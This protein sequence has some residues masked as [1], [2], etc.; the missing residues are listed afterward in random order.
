MKLRGF[1]DIYGDRE[2]KI[3]FIEQVAK[4]RLSSFL[5]NRVRFPLLESS[6][7]FE[8]TISTSDIVNKELYKFCDKGGRDVAL[9]PE[10]TA[11]TTRLVLD[12]NLYPGKF[13]YISP[14]FRYDRPQKGR[15]RQ[16]NQFGAEIVGFKDEFADAELLIALND[17]FKELGI[18][19]T[20]KVNFLGSVESRSRYKEYLTRE[21]NGES[22]C[23]DCSRRVS[24][25][26]LRVLDCKVC[27]FDL[28]PIV[29]FLLPE[30]IESY[31][32]IVS[33]SGISV[34]RSNIVR[35]LDYYTGFV[36]EALYDGVSLAAGGRYDSLYSEIGGVDLPAVGFGA[37]VERI[38]EYISLPKR[39]DILTLI[40]TEECREDAF[41]MVNQLRSIGLRVDFNLSGYKMKKQLS[42]VKSRY[43][44]ILG[45]E[46]L[47]SSLLTVRDM[48]SGKEDRVTIKDIIERWSCV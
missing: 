9:V 27:N 1:Q 46:E 14:F 10:G 13:Y 29:D 5:F 45:K 33:L 26:V 28:K 34:E 32:K 11:S 23:S 44:I 41:N 48:S 36:F 30:E 43:V 7:L 31:E 21:L 42:K 37:G 3:T 20:F 35:G 47:N 17:I 39:R 16:F 18:E 38:A 2:E 19:V 40:S 6:S 22:L 25:N 15:Y 24:S 8:R 12:N 4:R